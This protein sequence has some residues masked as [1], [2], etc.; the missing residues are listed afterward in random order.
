[1]I[2]PMS[3]SAARIRLLCLCVMA[4]SQP[5]HA[6]ADFSP[7][8]PPTAAPAPADPLVPVRALIVQERWRDAIAELNKVN[9]TAD[10]DWHNLMGYSHRKAKVPDFAAAQRHY[11]E[12]LRI[13]P[14]HRGALEYS[15]ELFLMKG[16]LTQAQARLATL[17]SVC[18]RDCHEY[19]LLQAAIAEHQAGNK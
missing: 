6:A 9:R 1:M 18:G 16:D 15:G 4:A 11:D 8:P 19:K 12:A 7:P 13:A 3:S 17:E 10:A 14:Q 5:V 2:N